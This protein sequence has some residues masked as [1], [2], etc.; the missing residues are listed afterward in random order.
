MRGEAQISTGMPA[1][2]FPPRVSLPRTVPVC[3]GPTSAGRLGPSAATKIADTRSDNAGSV[4]CTHCIDLPFASITV[5]PPSVLNQTLPSRS[6]ARFCTFSPLNALPS[7]YFSTALPTLIRLTDLKS[8]A[9][10]VPAGPA[11]RELPLTRVRD[12]SVCQSSPAIF[13]T[14]PSASVYSALSASTAP[15]QNRL[16]LPLPLVTTALHLVPSNIAM[17]LVPTIQTWPFEST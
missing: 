15:L 16:S 10:N 8:A 13:T 14:P 5:I 3:T 11:A 2:G 7:W 12:L 9:K 6:A 4:P 1:A 17:T